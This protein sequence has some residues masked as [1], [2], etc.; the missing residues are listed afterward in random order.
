MLTRTLFLVSSYGHELTLWLLTALSILSVAVAVYKLLEFKKWL[1][2]TNSAKK[3]IMKAINE[4]N[5]PSISSLHKSFVDAEKDP[6]TL[7]MFSYLNK[8]QIMVDVFDSFIISI[9]SH[10]ESRLGILASIGSNAPFVGLLGTIFGVMDAFNALGA[11]SSEAT[12]AVM[13]GISKALI[14]TAIGLLVAI[15]AIVSYNVLRRRITVIMQN[16]EYIKGGYILLKK[17]SQSKD[18]T[19]L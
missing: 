8:P 1:L 5:I 6:G 7:L 16:L 10:L 11:S 15:P 3:F 4:N 12:P 9:K 14:A 18:G 17:D 19:N 13:L 2:A